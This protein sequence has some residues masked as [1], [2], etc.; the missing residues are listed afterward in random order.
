M[1]FLYVYRIVP[2]LSPARP[3]TLGN[4]LNIVKNVRS[5]RAL[6]QHIYSSYSPTLDAI[7]CQHVSDEA[8][9]RFVIEGFLSGQGAYQQPSWRAV[10]WSLYWANE[11]HLA[12]HIRSFAEPVQGNESNDESVAH[13]TVNDPR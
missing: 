10:I 12:E 8:C 2:P 4:L 9:L 5:W 7:Q 3:L 11:I 6:G 1:L 13:H